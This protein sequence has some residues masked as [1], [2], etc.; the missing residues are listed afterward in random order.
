MNDYPPIILTDS[1]IL[2]AYYSAQ[3]NYHKSVCNFFEQCS[4][5]L[6]TTI[7][8]VTEVMYLL[9]RDYRTQNEF[10]DDLA[11]ELYRCI[12]L[13]QEDFTRIGEL[14]QQYADL[15]G[16]F[17]DLSLITV[18]ERLNISSI[19]TLDSD[20]DI[21]RRYRKQPFERVYLDLQR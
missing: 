5:E 2:F 14:N 3:D 20:F 11:Q 18:S 17:A 4:S 10:L 12:P 21:Y 13:I 19:I 15:P 1:S 6:I 16:D 9:S 8:C 7:P